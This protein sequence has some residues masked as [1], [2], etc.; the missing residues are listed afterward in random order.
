VNIKT[1]LKSS[2]A[3]AALLAI[4]APAQ[5]GSIANGKDTAS[6]TLSGHFNKAVLWQES[7]S[8]SAVSFVDNT[9]SSSRARIIAKGK[10]NEAVSVSG[11]FEWGMSTNLDGNVTPVDTATTLTSAN[12][13]GDGVGSGFFTV[14]HSYVKF[15]HKQLGSVSLGHTS[16]ATDGAAENNMTGATDVVYGG[17]LIGSGGI[18]LQA[19]NAADNVFTTKI[20]GDFFSN[21]DGGRTDVIK[22]T[23]PSFGGFSVSASADS[24]SQADVAAS[25]GGK[26]GGFAVDATIG[27]GNDS[28]GSDTVENVTMGSV[29]VGHDS[30]INARMSY[31]TTDNKGTTNKENDQL[32]IG[33]GYKAKLTSMGST[34]FAVDYIVANDV[35]SKGSEG[36]AYI[37]GVEQTTDAGVNFY[38]GG[39]FIETD[40]TGTSYEDVTTVIAGTKVFF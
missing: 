22:Y 29:A 9:A 21:G 16:Q 26:F 31:Q 40:I 36:K 8:A 33:L 17:S 30:G 2:V 13:H 23:T 20:V 39:S 3:A 35:E 24:D 19:N 1:T 15:D 10:M 5:A 38:L 4:A 25:F 7:G 37:F 11:V 14:R 34:N 27:Y 12:D 6:V 18:H 32:S 28:G